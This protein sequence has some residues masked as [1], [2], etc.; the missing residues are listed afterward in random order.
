MA[1]R[2]LST[3]GAVGLEIVLLGVVLLLDTTGIYETGPLFRYIPLLFVL[4]GV[5]APVV[6]GFRILI[7]P[8]AL[9]VV[10]GGIQLM[11][12]DVVEFEDLVVLWPVF[13]IR[14][15][16]SLLAGRF[17]REIPAVEESFRGAGT[18]GSTYSRSSV[19]LRT[20]SSASRPT[21]T[22]PTSSSPAPSPSG[23]PPSRTE[24]RP[25]EGVVAFESASAPTV[26][27]RAVAGGD[28]RTSCGTLG[29]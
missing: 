2:T 28:S 26:R 21:T 5:S 7:G 13:V 16:V 20:T 6:S 19:P 3:Q 27:G 25:R 29:R 24:R 15:G 4:M 22:R 10:A 11:A 18:S 17:R 23:A 12:L 14:F 1:N 8:I 9:I